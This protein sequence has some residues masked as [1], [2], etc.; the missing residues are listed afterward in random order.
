MSEMLTRHLIKGSELA[1]IFAVIVTASVAMIA[2]LSSWWLRR[3]NLV[4]PG[5]DSIFRTTRLAFLEL[6]RRKRLAVLAVMLSCLLARA[7]LLPVFKIPS[8]YDHDEY[9]YL[10]AGDTFAHG[11]L[12]NPPLHFGQFFESMH[13]NVR[14]TYMS[15]YPPGQGM[16]LAMGEALG[17]P[18]LAVWLL[19]GLMC[20]AICWALQAWMPP[21]WALLGGVLAVLQFG[22]L[23]YWVNTYYCASLPALGGALVLGGLPRLKRKPR[24]LYALLLAA[25][26]AI[27]ALTRPYE[28][29]IFCLPVAAAI[30]IWL[31]GKA[32]PQPVL[33]VRQ[34]VVAMVAV[35]AA[36][37]A[38]QAY[39]N[40]RVVGNALVMPYSVNQ[41]D[42]AVVPLFVWQRFRP[43]PAYRNV[44][45]RK[46]YLEW[47][48]QEY[49]QTVG[50]GFLRMTAMKF[51]RYLLFY[52]APFLVIPLAW[53]PWVWRDRR[54]RL[55]FVVLA[56]TLVG[57]E[58]EVWAHP[59]YAAPLTVIF[60]AL[61]VQ[62]LR[63]M[64]AQTWN[65]TALG[66]WLA[67]SLVAGCF[68]FDTAWISAASVHVNANRLY[69]MGNYQREAILRRLRETP[70]KH[71]VFVRYAP[72]HSSQ[73]EW[74]YNRADMERAK[75][76][77]ARDLGPA[78]DAKLIAY[79]Q[80]RQVWVVQ[81]DEMPP[82]LAPYDGALERPQEGSGS[83]CSP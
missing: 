72:S 81:P 54:L 82:R 13:I 4:P 5:R 41:R 74:V 67:I 38:F 1:L 15:M 78:C 25:G 10:L 73:Q 48:V 70:G 56:A 66:R 35:I 30:L 34:V 43:Q 80:S 6:A 77:W 61:A 26:V 49:R 46:Y 12:S 76:V 37:L 17:N 11:R 23:S 57:L 42:Y 51:Y 63:H 7:A 21:R 24:P 58:G 83:R 33:A 64:R 19:G 40:W 55:L 44:M 79:F 59:H 32:R 8:P 27:L 16:A 22:V 28:G 3:V 71:L 69:F 65:G 18:W 50:V 75:V 52:F 29:L 9:S 62:G 45:M 68:I 53:L 31:A 39:Y 2:M 47:E 36:T 14:P 20:G 60:I